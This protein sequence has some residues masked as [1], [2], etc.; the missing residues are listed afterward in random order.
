[1]IWRRRR[2]NSKLSAKERQD[3]N[4]TIDETLLTS[5]GGR[6]YFASII[7]DNNYVVLVAEDRDKIIGYGAGHTRATEDYRKKD[8]ILGQVETMWADDKYRGEGIGKEIVEKI[9]AALRGKGV[10]RIEVVASAGNIKAI[11][12]YKRE[13]YEEYDLVLEKNL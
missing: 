8:V 12:F 5:P 3:F 10:N 6:Q 13:G 7:D 2:L 1:M 4:D 11:D 9:E